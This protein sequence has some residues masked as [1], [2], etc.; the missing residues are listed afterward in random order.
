MANPFRRAIVVL[1]FMLAAGIACGRHEAGGE[2]AGMKK[3]IMV[4]SESNFRDEEFLE[5]REIFKK[6]GLEVKIASSALGEARGALGARVR[7]DVL[8]SDI[9]PEDFDAIVFVGGQ[10]ASRY[11][12]DPSVHKLIRNAAAD[13]KVIA[14]I[15]IAPVTLAKSGVLKGRR[16]TVWHSE[17]AQI[18]KAG[19]VYTAKGVERD[20]RVITASG[21]DYAGEFGREIVAALSQ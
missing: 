11:W 20:G 12:D 5:P 7:P 1:L 13:G 15:C 17:G 8:V 3:I 19:A 6:A 9:R 21:P 4:I 16:A 10:G 2:A 18:Q 14:A